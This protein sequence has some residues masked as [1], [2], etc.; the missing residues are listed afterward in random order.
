M[1]LNSLLMYLHRHTTISIS[2]QQK[3][4]F[5]LQNMMQNK[6]IS[7]VFQTLKSNM[8]LLSSLL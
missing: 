3:I 7:Q 4:R 6:S 2:L 5:T 1:F 8:M